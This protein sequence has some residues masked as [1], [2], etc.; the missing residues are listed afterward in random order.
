MTRTKSAWFGAVT[1]YWMNLM[2]SSLFFE[3]FMIA[4]Y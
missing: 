2:A 1:A 4:Q 3:P